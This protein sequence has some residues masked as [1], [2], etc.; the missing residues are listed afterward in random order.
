MKCKILIE[1]ELKEEKNGSFTILLPN[2]SEEVIVEISNKNH[3]GK[4]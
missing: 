2:F 1:G 4:K 3:G